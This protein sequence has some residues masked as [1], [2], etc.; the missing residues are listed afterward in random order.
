MQ[1]NTLLTTQIQVPLSSQDTSVIKHPWMHNS[2]QFSLIQTGWTR[3]LITYQGFVVWYTMSLVLQC[4]FQG[5]KLCGCR[6]HKLK[7]ISHNNASRFYYKI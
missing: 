1:V 2:S 7:K 4:N 5:I 6:F 3:K